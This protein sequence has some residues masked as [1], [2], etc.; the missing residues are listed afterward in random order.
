MKNDSREK[1]VGED[2]CL[3][4]GDIGKDKALWLYETCIDNE[5]DGYI[6]DFCL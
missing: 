4:C 5:R 1:V 3:K 2:I 6:S